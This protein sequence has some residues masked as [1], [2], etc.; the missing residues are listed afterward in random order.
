MT[1]NALAAGYSL[2]LP[3]FL[4]AGYRRPAIGALRRH[5]F[6]Y[7]PAVRGDFVSSVAGPMLGRDLL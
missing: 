7:Q 1:A 6:H 2:V 4:V 5:E 3:A